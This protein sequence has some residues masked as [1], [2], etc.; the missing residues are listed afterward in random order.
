MNQSRPK[1]LLEAIVSEL[2]HALRVVAA[3]A[4]PRRT[5]PAEGPDD[6][7][8]ERDRVESASLMRV[9]HAGE[10]AA[11]ALYRGQAFITRDNALR[12]SLLEAADEENDHLAWCEKR[13]GE[14]SDGPSVLA[15]LWYAGSF[16]I[17]AAAG[18]TGDR[19][20]LGFLA[21]TEKQ[22]TEH[23]ESHLERLPS[24]D[25]RSRQIVEKMRDEEQAHSENATRTGGVPLPHPARRLM[26][27]AS[28]VMTSVAHRI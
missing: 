4:V 5:S 11:Q 28:R 23:L 22:V 2:D 16:A 27:L 19:T 7:L 18:L 1:S 3:P 17:G 26:R 9:N 13:L 8:D 24:A 20:S 21:E 25:L 6:K 12:N 15:P 10:V 14:L